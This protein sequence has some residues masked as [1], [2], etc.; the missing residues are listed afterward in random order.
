A[1]GG[2]VDGLPP[3]RD[4]RTNLLHETGADAAVARIVGEGAHETGQVHVNGPHAG[5]ALL[6]A[7]RS[8]LPLV[9]VDE[10]RIDGYQTKL[11]SH[12][13]CRK[14]RRLTETNHGDVDRTADFQQARLLEVTDDEGVVPCPFRIQ[15]VAN[16]LRRATKFRQRMEEVVGRVE[17]MDLESDA[18]T[19]GCVE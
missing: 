3:R 6:E 5:D 4:Q 18:G 15:S 8:H 16:G 12:A 2:G 1:A 11:A 19:G 7:E 9:P 14:Q 17:A 13:Q 10:N